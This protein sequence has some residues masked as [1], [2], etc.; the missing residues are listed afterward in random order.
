MKIFII[1]VSS[2][3]LFTACS[4][5]NSVVVQSPPEQ[6][7][8]LDK[9]AS[10][11]KLKPKLDKNDFKGIS[12]EWVAYVADPGEKLEVKRYDDEGTS[13]I[14][15]FM[16]DKQHLLKVGDV[17]D[18][19]I[20]TKSEI[21]FRDGS[22][23]RL[24]PKSVLKIFSN[25]KVNLLLGSARI[26]IEK[27]KEK[28]NFELN[29]PNVTLTSQ[30]ADFAVRYNGSYKTTDVACFSGE[31]FAFGLTD[32]KFRKTYEKKV[33]TNAYMTI[34][35]VYDG[36]KEV[37]IAREPEKLSR[38]HKEDILKSFYGN[39]ED[40]DP[41][42]FTDISTSFLR[43]LMGIEYSAFKE[44]SNKYIGLTLG[45]VPLIH[46]ASVIYLEPYFEAA[47]A[48]PFSTTFYRTGG[49]VELQFYRG[50]Y[51]GGGGGIF[52]V[53]KAINQ[54]GK[55]FGAN[56]GYTFIKERIGFIDGVRLSYSSAAAVGYHQ[57]SYMFSILMNFY[58]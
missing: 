14:L 13:I 28:T 56:V 54:K 11:E 51:V 33:S 34:D 25:T 55:D 45:Y 46:I 18:T 44:F 4:S 15:S 7:V 21:V 58:K 2:L 1:A 42:E 35:T 37:Y 22:T 43:F 6:K 53:N 3:L 20:K 5:T 24:G 26:E 12:Q 39:M 49:R 17:L 9:A 57:N 48:N 32:S 41:W 52:W 47:F 10:I 50:F 29:A 8:V 23:L 27:N 31:L 40:V 16:A 36:T 19:S 30:E 38:E